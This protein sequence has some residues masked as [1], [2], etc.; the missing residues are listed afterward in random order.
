M[1]REIFLFGILVLASVWPVPVPHVLLSV[2]DDPIFQALYLL[3]V[4]FATE[5]SS[6]I[7]LTLAIFYVILLH[8]RQTVSYHEQ[9]EEEDE[10]ML[11][12][13]IE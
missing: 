6:L 2:V 11:E 7:G 10:E 5:Y 13:K 3:G 1:F 9:V 4:C 12:N 8:A